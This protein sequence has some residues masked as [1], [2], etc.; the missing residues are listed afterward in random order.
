MLAAKTGAI[1]SLP[2][3]WAGITITESGFAAHPKAMTPIMP[4]M[5]RTS[6]LISIGIRLLP[7]PEPSCA[8]GGVCSPV[9]N[10]VMIFLL[11][12]RVCSNWEGCARPI[13]R[14]FGIG[15][16]VHD[17]SFRSS[18]ISG[19]KPFASPEEDTVLTGDTEFKAF[20]DPPRAFDE[21]GLGRRWTDHPR[22]FLEQGEP[23][24]EMR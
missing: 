12:L 8:R 24:V 2:K 23:A 4:M 6:P 3:A 14:S 18:Q 22:G 16:I 17:L 10:L 9:P 13:G 7:E 20:C 15:A 21:M 11:Q 19:S 5:I 1:H